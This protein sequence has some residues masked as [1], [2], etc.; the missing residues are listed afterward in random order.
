MS[1]NL[2]ELDVEQIPNKRGLVKKILLLA[3]VVLLVCA[4]VAVSVF[5]GGFHLDSLRRW[6]K[7]MN[8]DEETNGVY[9]FDAHSSNRYAS[10]DGGLALASVSGL[11]T[12]D[13][14]GAERFL[15]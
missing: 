6:V 2:E 15:I 4:V 13:E 12:F 11:S 5:S 8:V 1:D 14:S 7:Y 9:S 10:F 3:V